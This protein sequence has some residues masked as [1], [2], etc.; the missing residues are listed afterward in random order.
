MTLLRVLH[1]FLSFHTKMLLHIAGFLS[2]ANILRVNPRGTHL[3][4]HPTSFQQRGRRGQRGEPE[5][6]RDWRQLHSLPDGTDLCSDWEPTGRPHIH[7]NAV[8]S[9]ICFHWVQQIIPQSTES[10]WQQ[11]K[12]EGKLGFQ[13]ARALVKSTAIMS[14]MCSTEL[15]S[16]RQR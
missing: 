4:R 12:G 1:L 14:W 11:H 2:V 8:G 16:N 6:S 10:H 15:I 5:R 13:T 3:D 7:C 9:A